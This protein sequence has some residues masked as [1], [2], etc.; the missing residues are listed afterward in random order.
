MK[1]FLRILC[2]GIATISASYSHAQCGGGYTQAKINWDN[3]DFYYNSG[4][5]AP[6][7]NYVTNTM[8]LTQKFAIG[9][10]TLTV[11]VGSNITINGENTL[12]TAEAGSYGTGAD[13]QF[14][15][16]AASTTITLT[17]TTEVQ[18][19]KFSIYD[20]DNNQRVNI[21]AQN[22]ASTSQSVTLSLANGASGITFSSNPGTN[23]RAN[24]IAGAYTNTDNNS[25]VNVDVATSVK[26]V[27][28]ALSNAVGD[29][30][31]SDISACVL[32]SF[33]INY[34]QLN[35]TT[36]GVANNRPFTGPTQN[37]ADYFLVTPDNQWAYYSDPVTGKTYGLFND[38][39]QP[40]INSLAYDP[41]NHICYYVTDGS[42]SS[43]GNQALK[44][45][46][47][48][49]GAKTTVI[50]DINNAPFNIPTMNLGVE[51]AGAAFYN[52]S[53]YL[54]IEGGQY[55]SSN[56]RKTNI[57]RIDFDAS[58]NPT[59]A[60]QV[61]ATPAYD[62]S[63]GASIHDW[64]DFIIKDG[65]LYDF[66]TARSG[67]GCGSYN[68]SNSSVIHYD[69][70]TD[71]VTTTYPHTGLSSATFGGQVAMNWAGDIYTFWYNCN[72][73]P[74]I[75]GVQKYNLN[76]TFAVNTN[77]TVISGAA[78]PGGAG[79]AS[80]PFRPKCDLGD[81]PASYDP[82]PVSPA[83][84]ERTDS[85]RLGNTWDNEFVKKGITST[86]DADDGLAYVP[87]FNP[88]YG[89]Y[90][91]QVYVYNNSGSNAT[92]CA[93]LDYNGNGVFDAS[94]G[95]TTTVSSSTSSQLI[96]L[97][98][99]STPSSLPFGSYTYLRVRVTS[100]SAGMTTAMPTGYFFN[101]EVEDYRIVVN[102][103]PLTVQYSDF[104][105]QLTNEKTVKL[106]WNSYDESDI[107][108]YSIERSTN[109][110]DWEAI[111]FISS[112][113]SAGL[114]SHEAIDKNVKQ[115]ISYY[116]LKITEKNGKAILSNVK[117][118]ENKAR[119]SMTIAPNPV[120]FKAIVNI[121]S[122]VAEKATL[123]VIN[124][125][126]MVVY[127]ESIT[128]KKGTNSLELPVSGFVN[129]T[130]IVNLSAG[131]QSVRQSLIINK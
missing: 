93:W 3:L 48:L 42:G 7:S 9:V 39:A 34:H 69:M 37:Q 55:N 109:N 49:T 21:S 13:V 91:T 95:I 77:I 15:T 16:T 36:N 59:G 44:K 2:F 17:F 32:G 23:P 97:Y 73:T 5:G 1:N 58:L 116:R 103:Y 20:V 11:G 46:D 123:Q 113:M 4:G 63:T 56:T 120:I 65:I 110:T 64:G 87:I 119:F 111:N 51:S 54:G 115:G 6:Y 24:G 52:G 61:F 102:T 72:P 83:V 94:E 19:L 121:S 81:A 128:I 122:A 84:H 107:A 12:N 106:N 10:N 80:D 90:L 57:Y 35:T 100:A 70:T 71:N 62:N 98:W 30:W 112:K 117:K 40:Y 82:N 131:S 125:L 41:V 104:N 8:A 18:N 124:N 25:T 31:L 66:N 89:N 78:W 53:L 38:V 99:P 45:Y 27:T 14:T 22:A 118:I 127:K 50:A 126:G 68:W 74:D 75:G 114:A 101:G 130:Y 108:S 79:D 43:S 29:F 88:N 105:A 67:S 129:G 86:E 47:L 92:V 33:P 28:I 26:I 76:G 96:W 60:A 85:I